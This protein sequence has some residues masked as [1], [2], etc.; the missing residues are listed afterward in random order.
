MEAID[1]PRGVLRYFSTMDDPRV[2]H[3]KRHDLMDMIVIALCAV[4]CG[5]DGW[6]Q[7]EQF[8]R[9]K[10]KW[11]R[12]FLKLPHDIPSHDTFG[13]VFARLDPEQFE[14]CFRNWIGALADQSRGR[15]VAIDGKTLR[16]SF[17][18]ASKKAAIHMVSAWC[19]SNQMVLG[20]LATDAK[21]NEIQ[22]VP[23]LLELLD[24]EG[25]VVTAD[26]LNCQKTIARKTLEAKADYLLQ[27]KGNQPA[28][29][30]ELQLLFGQ[31]LRDDCQGIPYAYAEETN[32]GHGRVETRRLWSTWEVQW[33]A[34]RPKWKG[35]ASFVCVERDCQANGQRTVERRYYISS[36]EGRDATAL[37][38]W[39]RGHWSIE[40]QLHWSLDVSFR[41]DD[42][43]IRQGHAAENYSRLCR[44][45]LNLLKADKSIK[46]G[47]KGKRK[48]A[49]W[50]HDY[51]L[52]LIT[53]QT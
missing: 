35:L 1:A 28:L 9:C 32:G 21:S 4:I 17:D 22:T 5:A 15:L 33:F 48:T 47:I 27:V 19:Q 2:N 36:L 42:R 34:D 3:G 41:E 16:R 46:L 52:S 44:I 49:G 53:Q 25:A 38:K 29:H 40:N 26:A 43:R 50:D 31:G 23:K 14:Q 51:L 39:V 8:G 18:R 13:R 12:T 30:E 11:F 45:A 24:L 20:Q 10:L 37:L 6:S 7:V